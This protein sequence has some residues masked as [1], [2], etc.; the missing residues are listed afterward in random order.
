MHV[1][2]W[3][4]LFQRDVEFLGVTHRVHKQQQ[5]RQMEKEKGTV[6]GKDRVEHIRGDT[7]AYTMRMYV[8]SEK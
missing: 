7:K 4:C 3:V 6:R 8:K 2:V 1:C 5:R